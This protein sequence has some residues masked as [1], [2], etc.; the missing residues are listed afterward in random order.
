MITEQIAVST[1]SYNAM[2]NLL[3]VPVMNKC[4]LAFLNKLNIN[5]LH[6]KCDNFLNDNRTC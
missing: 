6:L 4:I 1:V 3:P 2:C 5:W